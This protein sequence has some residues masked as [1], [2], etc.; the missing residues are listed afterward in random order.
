MARSPADRGTSPPGKG[1]LEDMLG[2]ASALW[3]RLHAN[4]ASAFGPLAEKWSFSKSTN[5]WSVQLKRKQRAVVYLIPC[6]GHFLA[7]FALG[8][9]A[10]A[11]AK[12]GGLPA[13]V[14]AVI[15]AAPRYPEGR[16]VR[17]EVR[18]GKDV[19]NVTTIAAIK[20]AH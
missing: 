2:R 14:L 13:S 4:L 8:E 1:A 17:L 19:A 20:M 7:A 9:K 6:R 16:G 10:C 18:S 3:A 5:R 12:Q 11:A 15:E